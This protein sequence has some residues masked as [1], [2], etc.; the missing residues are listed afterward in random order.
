MSAAPLTE[1]RVVRKITDTYAD[2]MVLLVATSVMSARPGIAWAGAVMATPGALDDLAAQ[3]FGAA[4]LAGAGANDIVLAVHAAGEEP[5]AAALAA[6]ADSIFSASR[7]EAGA[8]AEAAP[9]TI[10]AARERSPEANVAIISVPGPYA[11]L[12]AHHALTAGLHVLLFSDNVPL[13]EEV[14]LKQRA[15]ELG[16]LVMGPGAG[17]AVLAGTG[18]GFA[19]VLRGGPVGVVAAAGTGAQEVSALLDRWGVGV[20]QVIGVGGRDLSAEVSGRMAAAAVRALDADPGTRAILV[21]SKPPDPAVARLVLEERAATPA[22]AVFMGVTDMEPP[23]GVELAR[24]LEA[25]AIAAARLVGK[26]PDDPGQG[27]ADSAARVAARL[28]EH[29]RAIRGFYS[30]GTLC[31]EAQLIISGLLGPVYSNEPLVHANSVPA[32]PGSHVLLD[33]G[34]EE[35]TLGRPHPMI[36]PQSRIEILR[37]QA[38]APEVA[39]VLL[40]VVLGYGSHADPAAALAPVLAEVMAD[41]GPQVV[42]YVLGSSGDPQGYARQRAAL[43]AAG[44]LVT[45][46]AARAAYLAAAIAARKPEIAER[47][48]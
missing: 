35:Y 28:P 42:A 26:T 39:V 13:A 30:G 34:A 16:L 19:N 8:G 12:E 40:D 15:T 38:S 27:L 25:G 6:G 33:L 21:V 14:E 32:P 36:D 46:T 1:C 23:S 9:R 45:E 29:R 47:R 7:K 11:A 10:E 44:C 20:S 48:D 22:V 4:G 24:T 3:G 43:E 41:D 17:T 31:Y 5:A 37:A 18:L 2:S